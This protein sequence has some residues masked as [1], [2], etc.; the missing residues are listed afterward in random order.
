MFYIS[1]KESHIYCI[2]YC[3]L[4]ITCMVRE[5]IALFYS[6]DPDVVTTKLDFIFRRNNYMEW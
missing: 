2:L 3:I 5:A 4:Y 6:L 1:S